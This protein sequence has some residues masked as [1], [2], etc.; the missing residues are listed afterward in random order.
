MPGG[1]LEAGESPEECVAREVR[2]ELGLAIE[3]GPLLDA[4]V[5]EPL[6]ERRVLVLAY[7]CF[8]G[9]FDGMAHGAEHGALGAFEVD[10]WGEIDLPAGYARVLGALTTHRGFGILAASRA[11]RSLGRGQEARHRVLVPGSQVRVLPPQPRARRKARLRRGA[12]RCP[13]VRRSSP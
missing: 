4:W 3:V 6:P 7:G 12:D 10:G 2:E 11:G 5:Y 13:R 9:N 1:R 8:A